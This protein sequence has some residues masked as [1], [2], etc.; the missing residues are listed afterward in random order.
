MIVWSEKELEKALGLSVSFKIDSGK[1]DFNSKDINEGDIFI[2]LKGTRDGHDFVDDALAR[3]ASAVIVSKDIKSDKAVIVEDTNE[4]LIKLAEYKRNNSKTK[5]VGI[6]GSVGKTSTKEITGTFLSHFADTYYN[7]GSFNNHLGVPL[8]VASIPV[9]TVYSVNEMGMNNAG[10]I[11]EL[12]KL[13]KPDVAII[14]IIGEAHLQNLGT[15]ENICKAKCEIFEGLDKEGTA[16]INIDSPYYE[17]QRSI[18]N[19]LGIKNIYSFGESNKADCF[20]SKFESTDSGNIANYN[21][22][23]NEFET[24][25]HLYGKH[26]SVN[27]AACLLAVHSFGNKIDSLKSVIESIKP[28]GG[29]G[30]AKDIIYQGRSVKIIDDAYNANPTSVRAA[31][32]TLSDFSGTKIAILSDMRELGENENDL[33]RNLAKNVIDSGVTHFFGVC[34]LMKNLHDELKGKIESHHFEQSS[35]ENFDK[36]IKLLPNEDMTILVKGSNSTKVRDFVEYFCQ[37]TE[38]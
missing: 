18:L 13:V 27:I 15:M 21:F 2:A 8:S 25:N 23:G 30:I 16:I 24:I 12:T 31:L 9:N 14:T 3:G 37:K 32:S 11:R 20:L 5:F 1:V 6:T 28:Y 7:K 33:H 26:Q 4:A 29:R 22:F 36:I 10:E 38:V 35:Q 34:S 19:D 17:L